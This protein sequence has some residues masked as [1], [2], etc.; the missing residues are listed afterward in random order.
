MTGQM[1]TWFVTRT[2][3][4]KRKCGELSPVSLLSSKLATQLM[5]PKL[6]FLVVHSSEDDLSSVTPSQQASSLL[7]SALWRGS[8]ACGD[9]IILD[10]FDSSCWV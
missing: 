10:T 7:L 8:G 3:R 1:P 4:P 9:T 5:S 6:D 2:A